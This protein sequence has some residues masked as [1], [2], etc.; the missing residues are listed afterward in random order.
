MT[1]L[2]IITESRV[3]RTT[4]THIRAACRYGVSG[5]VT[6]R[7][8]QF[9]F[10]ACITLILQHGSGAGC[11]T[12]NC[13][14]PVVIGAI[15]HR[16]WLHWIG[17]LLTGRYRVH[18]FFPEAFCV[19]ADAVA[20]AVLLGTR[21]CTVSLPLAAVLRGT[22]PP[23]AGAERGPVAAAVRSPGVVRVATRSLGV[24]LFFVLIGMLLR[25]RRKRCH[26]HAKEHKDVR[27]W[28]DDGREPA[29]VAEYPATG[30]C[31][32]VRRIDR[33]RVIRYADGQQPARSMLIRPCVRHGQ[34][35]HER[36]TADRFHQMMIEP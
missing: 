28:A 25:S 35:S 7:I 3:D 23:P 10:C 22:L 6:W 4:Y 8:T 11:R 1:T 14:I 5:S 21:S 34:Q 17:T 31:A 27:S 29:S 15:D 19:R 16:C 20:A 30:I 2:H 32:E 24:F 18:H 33:Q 13:S 12:W 26:H 36:I 9:P